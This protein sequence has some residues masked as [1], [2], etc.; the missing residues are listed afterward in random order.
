MAKIKLVDWSVFLVCRCC[1][2]C[3]FSE[4]YKKLFYM[5]Q[6]GALEWGAQGWCNIDYSQ[7]LKEK[8]SS[9][10]LKLVSAVFLFFHQMIYLQ[11]LRKMLLIS[12]KKFRSFSRYSNFCKYFPSFP[13]FLYS[14]QQMN[15]K[16]F[17]MSWI[18]L[19]KLAYVIFAITQN[20]L[21][22]TSLNLVR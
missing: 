5:W 4:K 7:V 11:K 6:L 14:E 13:H 20:L 22:I 2:C 9:A 1:C 17:M 8:S 12:S 15:E 3:C 10:N 16:Q 18:G 21:H 19:H